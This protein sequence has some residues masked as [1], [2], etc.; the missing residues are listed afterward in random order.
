MLLRLT[1]DDR[2]TL[3]QNLVYGD[4]SLERLYFVGKHRL[5]MRQTRLSASEAGKLL[6]PGN[7]KRTPSFQPKMQSTIYGPMYTQCSF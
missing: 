4:K 2:M 1:D 7:V 6:E 3:L 5:P